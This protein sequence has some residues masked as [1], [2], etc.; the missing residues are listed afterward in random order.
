ML[1]MRQPMVTYLFSKGR[2]SARI[3]FYI[4]A[5]WDLSDPINGYQCM[6]VRPRYVMMILQSP[7]HIMPAQASLCYRTSPWPIE[8]V[9]EMDET[10]ALA[11]PRR[12]SLYDH[13]SVRHFRLFYATFLCIYMHD[14]LN[15]SRNNGLF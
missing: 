6:C 14:V 15:D 4:Q 10:Y 2:T 12:F 8:T 5:E 3:S 11:T 1:T 7:H 9:A 13:S